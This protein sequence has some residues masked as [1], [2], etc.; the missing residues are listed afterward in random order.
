[1][2]DVLFYNYSYLIFFDVINVLIEFFK[3]ILDYKY[4]IFS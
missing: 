2:M 3:L 4:Y 1:M